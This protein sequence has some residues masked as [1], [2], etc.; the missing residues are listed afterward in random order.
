MKILGIPGSL[1][2]GSYNRKLLQ[3][4]ASLL[5]AGAKLD[6][7]E[8]EGIPVYN[9]DLDNDMPARVLEF[10]KTIRA[11]DAILICTPEYNYAIPGPLK[12]AIDWASRPYGQSAWKGKPVAIMG[13]STGSLGTV[14][15]QYQL[16]QCF[17][18][19]DMPAVRQPEVMVGEAVRKFD[20]QGQLADETAKNLIGMLLTELVALAESKQ[21]AAV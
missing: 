3:A 7:F 17:V 11:A 8:L 16:R 2:K 4:A 20:A 6:V 9:Q 15:A 18:T 5:P 10:K 21:T 14:R 12:N 1:R 13:A 19:L